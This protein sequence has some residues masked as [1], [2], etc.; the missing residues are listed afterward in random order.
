MS[1]SRVNK[2]AVVVLLTAVCIS[3]AAMFWLGY[4]TS[5]FD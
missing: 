1:S 3:V 5:V 4:V 2:V